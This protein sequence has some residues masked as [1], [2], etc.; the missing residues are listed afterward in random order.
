MSK[1]LFK[2]ITPKNITAYQKRLAD[3]LK[4]SPATVKR[5]LSSIRKFCEWA[6]KQGY[7]E[8]N[9][10]LKETETPGEFIS[11]NLTARNNV[12][13]KAY[14]AYTQASI[15]KYFHYAIL[16]VFCAAIGFGVYDQFFK[17]T[18]TPL[19]YP[20]ALTAPN[21]FLS[22]QG[23]LTDSSDN[24]ISSATDITFQ[25]WNVLSGG[26]EGTCTGGAGE[27]CLWTSGTCSVSPDQDGIF[28][29]L[30]GTT[31]GDNYTCST[32]IEIPANVFTENTDLWVAITVDTDG[33]MDPRMQIATVGYALNAETLQ[34]YPPGTEASMIPYI[35]S[36]GKIVLAAASPSIQATSGTFALEGQ[37][38][39][40]IQVADGQDGNITLSPKGTGTVNLTSE[41]TTGNLLDNEGGVN[42]GTE[43]GKEANN[44]YYGYV[45]LDTTNFNLLKLEAG[46]TPSAKFTVDASG[47]ASAAGILKALTTGSY[48]TGDITVSGGDITGANSV[49]LD[50][51]EDSADYITSSVGLAVGGAQTYYINTSTS[52]LNALVLAGDL[53]VD[54]N[55]LFIDASE[56]KIGIGTTTLTERLTLAGN[57]TISGTLAL[58][59]NVEFDAGICNAAA[60][61]K[62][63][64]DG[65]ANKYYY[66]NGTDWTE[67]GAGGGGDSYWSLTDDDLSP[68]ST[69]Y[70]VAIG[71]ADAGTAK[72]YVNGNVGIGTSS[73]EDLLEIQGAQDTDAILT[74]DADEGDDT[75][76]TWEIRSEATGNDLS[77]RNNDVEVF[78]LN[79]AG[80]L[81][82]DGDLAISGGNITTAVTADSTLTVTGTLT[83]NGTLDA[84]GIFTLGDGGET[85]LINTSDWGIDTTGDMTN[86]GDIA[87]DG[88]I[89]FTGT[90]IGLGTSN[91]ITTFNV[92]TGTA[93]NTFNIG[94]NNTTKDTLNI[95]SALDDVIINGAGAN[96]K[97]DFANFD[98]AATGN[99]ITAGDLAVNG[100]EI[101]SDG[102]LTI[103]PAD[104]QL[105]L[106]G[107]LNAGGKNNVAYN[108]F[109]D[110]GD[111]PE[112]AAIAQDNDLYIGGDIEVDGTI[113]GNDI[114]CTDC[115]D[116]NDFEDTLDLDNNLT[117]NQST[118]TWTQNFTGTTTT[119]LTYNANNLTSGSALALAST[120]TGLTGDLATITLS[121]SD[122]ANTGSL[123]S[124]VNS[125]VANTNTSFYIKHYATGT[126]NLAMRV[127]DVSGDTTPFVI[128]GDG[129]VGI[130][131][132]SPG[133]KLENIGATLLGSS[134]TGAEDALSVNTG[135][136]FSGNLLKLAVNGT[137]KIAIDS[138]GMLT[139]A[140]GVF[141]STVADAADAIGFKLITP[142]YTTAG[143]KLLS[144]W[145]NTDEK[146]SLD[147]DGVLALYN[148]ESMI[149][150]SSGDI[151]ID[152][153]SGNISFATNDLI[154]IDDLTMGGTASISG[155]PNFTLIPTTDLAKIYLLNGGDLS[156][157]TSVGGD[158]G[159]VEKIR[160]SNDGD[161]AIEGSLYDL[162]GDTLT[163]DD[164][165][166]VTGIADF[167][168]SQV[169]INTSVYAASFIDTANEDYFV[170]P[171]AVTSAAL[172]GK[173]GIGNTSPT[174]KLDVTGDINF[175]GAFREDGV[176]ILSGMISAFNGSCPTGWTEYTAARGRTVVGTP[177][178]GTNAGTVGTALT[179]L[180]DKTHTHQ[181]YE[182]VQGSET[183]NTYGARFPDANSDMDGVQSVQ[184]TDTYNVVGGISSYRWLRDTETASTSDVIP[185]IQLTYCQKSAG[186]DLA[187]WIPASEDISKETIVSI[188]PDNREKIIASKKAYDTGVVGIIASQP[189]WLIGNEET[190]SVQMALA[191][192]VPTRVSLMNGEIKPGDPITTSP[193]SGVGMKATQNGPIVGKAMEA[194]N[195]TSSL[196]NCLNLETGR[197]EKC[198]TILVFVNISWFNPNDN[199][200]Q[201]DTLLAQAGG[202]YFESISI[203]NDL[204]DGDLVSLKY[205][206]GWDENN[207]QE[208]ETTTYLSKASNQHNAFI[209]VIS[210]TIGG[211]GELLK[212]ER[213]NNQ[214]ISET[215]LISFGNAMLKIDPD[216]PSIK[217]GDQLTLTSNNSYAGMATKAV[218][219][220]PVVARALE[221]W[222]P[223]SG[224]EK[225]KAL[226]AFGWNDPDIYL[227]STGELN[228][229]N[230]TQTAEGYQLK[231]VAGRLIEKVGAFAEIAAAKIKAGRIETQELISPLAEIEEI[232]SNRINLTEITS[233]SE[234]GDIVINLE[235][236]N[237]TDSAFG[238]LIIN[239]QEGQE[240]ASVD[241][242]GNATFAGTLTAN[243]AT[244]TGTLYAD[245]IITKHGKFGDLLVN[246]IA[247]TET[248]V[249]SMDE[250]LI[251]EATDSAILSEEEINN[252]IN[253]ILA[254]VPEATSPAEL[255]EDINIPNDL[256]IANSLNIGGTLSLADNAVNTLSG[257]LY[258]QSLG[259]GG[260]DI[261][262]GKIVIDEH[263]N[264]I[265]EGD[266]TI[267]GRLATKTISPLPENDLV[268]DLA[269]IPITNEFELP[270]QATQSAFG[271]LLI[272]GFEGETVAS[273]DASGSAFFASLG[274]EADYTATESGVIMAAADNYQENGEYSPAIKTNA[275]A[276]VGLLP[277]NESEIMIY[278]PKITDQSLIYITPL[279]DTG[280]KVV[281]VKAKKAQKNTEIDLEGNEIPEEKGWFKVAID[282]PIDKE[283]QF[284]WWIVN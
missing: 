211:H 253:E 196:N 178:S 232:K 266:V 20:E 223:E 102:D 37:T 18:P 204:S 175:T 69:D 78:N 4:L 276:G 207:P 3:E 47:N 216:S 170:D 28:S 168:S 51:G 60:A 242:E 120:S 128:D 166:S 221:G 189:G 81:Q 98:V 213:I 77:L 24:P 26:D 172:Y 235:N 214:I 192:R 233:S 222:T 19:A 240:V 269:Q 27:E 34:G 241:A 52:N 92:G 190:S 31:S 177:A 184:S 195:E 96:S 42:F 17:K 164:N 133:V 160:I 71:A 265:F 157:Y 114:A 251:N 87:A 68:L 35:D 152:A 97:I 127:D 154:N 48:F 56:N 139:T 43:G 101:T 245:E 212:R 55:D 46:E 45:G 65:D 76:D 132:T 180:E 123:L 44:L 41:A 117:L 64:Y 21:R 88:T 40:T 243:E 174:Y 30:L 75:T 182:Y 59:P 210:N 8:I 229:T 275:T 161:L 16:I 14:R 104:G 201:Q 256:L 249:E 280:N 5:R 111:A 135:A 156:L 145:N 150:N 112:E 84:N 79:T 254:S 228:I 110:S 179:D 193:I 113:Y 124:L 6:Q 74:L 181:Y 188:D 58:G 49:V 250:S 279:N 282:M 12:F 109:A 270:D 258:L 257:P 54:T 277:A 205:E 63:Y 186:A 208:I 202:N 136:A 143:A 162:T 149:Y 25:L 119:G 264:A 72:L 131:T 116:F 284:S 151:T 173:V 247:K 260:I 86:I 13:Q 198:G 89:A 236:Q 252:L 244:I 281:F 273:I 57:A 33:E 215:R 115:L 219:V 167:N 187:E 153:A 239:G 159:V 129:N 66:C 267:K 38:G 105:I 9:P 197:E 171:A 122:A 73:P 93:G 176:E 32:A 238:K 1:D 203:N 29:L 140:S 209:G 67:M 61:G 183:G 224:K 125:G 185:Y 85:G 83:A 165:L 23:R 10:F 278:N 142:E 100:D 146:M 230:E 50:I 62:M 22:F 218:K 15:T 237:S 11:Q 268:I 106:A 90:T 108:A 200:N 217:S 121:G 263:G 134:L 226:I 118:Y 138:T 199:Q 261:L 271:N 259:L 169:T 283:I 95:G 246:E 2:K 53:T 206:Q 126:N 231:D 39:I 148:S 130:G 107:S 220:G 272:K 158:A 82:I 262:A 91:S 80:D 141:T 255:S 155:T 7:L 147:K 103:T 234:S 36:T 99:I 144:V 70:N 191:G 94:T 137:Q 274:I 248:P 163:I 194:L 227:T 225:I